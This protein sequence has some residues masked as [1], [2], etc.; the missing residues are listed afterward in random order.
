MVGVVVAKTEG[1]G[2]VVQVVMKVVL[3]MDQAVNSMVQS[4]GPPIGMM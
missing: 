3:E 1:Q 2:P 4:L